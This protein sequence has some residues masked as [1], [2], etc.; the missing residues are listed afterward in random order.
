MDGDV[1]KGHAAEDTGAG[2]HM[3]RGRARLRP[4]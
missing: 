3:R 2:L 1:V 4:A